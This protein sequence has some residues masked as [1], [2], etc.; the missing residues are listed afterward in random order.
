MYTK[1]F[2]TLI[3]CGWAYGSTLTLLCLCRSGLILGDIEV[4]LS[5][6][7]DVISWLRLK[8][9]W[10]AFH[11]H[12]GCIQ[13][14]LA[15]WYAMNGHMGPPSHCYACACWGWIFGDNEVDGRPELEWWCN[16]MVDAQTPR[17]VHSI[18]ILD[19]CK[20]FWHLGM[21]WM[22]IWVHPYSVFPVQVGGGFL[23]NWGRPEPEW[24]CNAMVE[25]TNP[26]GLHPTSI[27]DV[28]KV[29]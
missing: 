21:L 22:G 7:D 18:S 23:G 14:V 1:C 15:P 29:F 4:D 20:V 8:P 12:I 28:Y 6:S 2:S 24:C 19:V 13:S 27:L 9:P 26:Y 11:I 16:V 25:A 17:G 10:S 3:C 5:P